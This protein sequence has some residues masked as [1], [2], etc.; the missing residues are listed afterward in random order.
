MQN[1]VALQVDFERNQ[2]DRFFQVNGPGN[3]TRSCTARVVLS[4]A[5]TQPMDISLSSARQQVSFINQA[6]Q[7]EVLVRSQFRLGNQTSG[8]RALQ[9]LSQMPSMNTP[10]G[11]SRPVRA[12]N[13]MLND[14]NLR[15][16]AAGPVEVRS[17]VQ[18]QVLGPNDGAVRLRNLGL[19][20]LLQP[21]QDDV[22]DP[23]N[24]GA[25]DPPAI[26]EPPAPIAPRPSAR[27]PEP[28]PDP[29]PAPAMPAAGSSDPIGPRGPDEVPDPVGGEADP[30]PSP[31][32][33]RRGFAPI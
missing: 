26:P 25:I 17:V 29:A 3:Q 12:A 11:G 23:G 10:R 14:I 22:D 21:V 9:L 1:G 4:V 2:P 6:T 13:V 8:V 24:G 7:G 33:D 20:L 31:G 16:R 27:Q 18:L 19:D 5:S 30:N 15:V 32:L 28:E